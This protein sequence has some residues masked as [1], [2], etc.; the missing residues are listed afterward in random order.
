VYLVE[1]EGV[2]NEEIHYVQHVQKKKKLLTTFR[3][4]VFPKCWI[5]CLFLDHTS[6]L[7]E[8]EEPLKLISLIGLYEPLG[9][10]SNL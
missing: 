2:C 5:K 3:E 7:L 1:L 6:Y 10:L 8:L 9:G 4:N